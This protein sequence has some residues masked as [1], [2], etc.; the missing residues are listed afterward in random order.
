[1]DIRSYTFN[2]FVER[3]RVFHGYAAPGVLVGG[4]MV[5]LAYKHLPE[6]G[7]FDVLCETPK[8][9]PDAVQLLTPCTMG[10]GWLTILNTGRYALVI[11]DKSTG[12]GVR[13]SMDAAK[14]DAW[15]EIKGWFLKLIPKPDQDEERLREEIEAA[16]SSIFSIRRVRIADCIFRKKRRGAIV[17]CTRCSEAYPVDDGIVCL[18]CQGEGLYAESD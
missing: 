1:M 16:G 10:N 11:Y 5:D 13:I 15:P 9:L 18:H 17:I 4:F 14:L 6:E 8:C 2:E 7:L 3:V 12:E